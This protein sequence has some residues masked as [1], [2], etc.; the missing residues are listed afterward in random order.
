[1]IKGGS[2]AMPGPIGSASWAARL[3]VGFAVIGPDAPAERVRML[4]EGRQADLASG[5]PALLP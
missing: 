4:E 3:K 5:P 1:M 2:K